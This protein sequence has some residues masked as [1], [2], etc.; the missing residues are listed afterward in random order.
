MY[1]IAL[2]IDQART[3]SDDYV[4][5]L[6]DNKLNRKSSTVSQAINLTDFNDGY[7]ASKVS[8]GRGESITRSSLHQMDDVTLS[9]LNKI[10]V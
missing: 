3:S 6:K 2:L 4:A 5:L 9:R 7:I 8:P 1:F 10:A